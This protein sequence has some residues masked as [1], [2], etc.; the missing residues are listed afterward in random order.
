MA[1]LDLNKLL[2]DPVLIELLAAWEHDEHWAG[3]ET[4]RAS[5]AGQ[6]HPGTGEPFEE[7]W[8]RQRE[9]KYADL[10]EGQ[11]E[12][13]REEVRHYLAVIRDYVTALAPAPHAAAGEVSEEG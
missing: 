2:D 11:K 3:W 5:K 4:Y 10:P 6:I 1:A 8:K 9:T 13:D 7:R 12:S